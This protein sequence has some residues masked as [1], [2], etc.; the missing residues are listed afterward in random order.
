MEELY[1]T[2]MNYCIYNDITSLE[3]VCK[4]IGINFDK[5]LE[6]SLSD[7]DARDQLKLCCLV[8][9]GRLKNKYFEGSISKNECDRLIAELEII[10]EVYLNA[11]IDSSQGDL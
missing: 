4:G 10:E 11:S 7:K 3:D 6:Y 9:V 2:L 8:I 1:E 5:I